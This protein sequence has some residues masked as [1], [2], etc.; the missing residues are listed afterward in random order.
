MEPTRRSFN[1]ALLSVLAAPTLL[2]GAEATTKRVTYPGR[3][4]APESPLSLWYRSPAVEWTEALPLGNGSLGAMVFGGVMDEHLQL[5]QDTFWSGHPSDWD[6]PETLKVLPEI[7]KLVFDG[8]YAEANELA[9]KMMGQYTQSYQPMADLRITFDNPGEISDY[10]RSLD[11]ATAIHTTRYKAGDVTYTRECFV[12]HADQVLVLRVTA[13][14]PGAVSL[15][16]KIECPHKDPALTAD[17]S[18]MTLG[19]Q[20]KAPTQVDP[21]G[22]ETEHP[23]VYDPA[24]DSVRFQCLLRAKTE[25]GEQFVSPQHLIIKNATAVTLFL[26]AGTSYNGPGKSP[27]KEGRSAAQLASRD[28]EQAVGRP[29]KELRDAHVADHRKLFDRVSLDLGAPR[30]EGRDL[31]T[32]ERVNKLGADDP[33]NVVLHFQYGRYLLICSARGMLPPNL[34]GIWNDMI[35]PPWSSNYTTN[36]NTEMNHWPAE[37]TN[38]SECHEPLFGFIE[39]LAK[40]GA[41]T[42]KVEYGCR[43]WCCHHNTDAWAQ[44]GMPGGYGRG[45]NARSALWPMAAPWLCHHFYDHYLF[46]TDRKFLADRAY[47]AMKGACEFYLDFLMDDG[48]GRL[49]TCPSTSPE[50]EFVTES[51]K[52]SSVAMASTMDMSLIRDLFGNTIETC[53]V[54]GRDEEFRQQLEAAR[55]KLVPLQIGPDGRLQEWFKPFK[56]TDVHHR[57]PS[58]LWGVYPGSEITPATPELFAAAR[59]SLEVRGDV[60]TGWSSG[61]KINLWARFLDGDHAMILVGRTLRVAAG[62]VYPNLFGSHPPF[63][64]DGNYAFPAGVSE[65][66]LQSHAGEVHLLPALPKVWPAGSVKGLRARGNFGVDLAWKEGKLASAVITSA[67]GGVCKLRYRDKTA[68]LKT[69]A[70][71][72]Y[73]IG[74]ELKSV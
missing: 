1:A 50:N 17:T 33:A 3:V 34:Q 53:K 36:I 48:Q 6:N 72:R 26:S 13:D 15:T 57:H 70:G 61:W 46:T 12:S 60:A 43:G 49:V 62:G 35:T 56:E 25:G 45:G 51:G 44:T 23:V 73:E 38:L 32:D 27:A 4:A 5:N 7:R 67:A 66:L 65:M 41:K 74:P 68:E 30:P 2:R 9:K 14:K 59:K 39:A 64:M 16:A 69:E 37:V 58:H 29:Y 8:K 18:S 31:Q 11:L 55:A 47:P 19:L 52:R 40:N 21:K 63:Q 28:L 22:H 71:K 10:R 24:G 42:A 20:G 54:L